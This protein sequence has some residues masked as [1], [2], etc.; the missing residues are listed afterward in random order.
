VAV[1]R[2]VHG[3][4]VPRALVPVLALFAVMRRRPGAWRWW[5]AGLAALSLMTAMGE[6]LPLRGWLYDAFLPMRYFRHSAIFR[7]FFLFAASR[8]WRSMVTRDLAAYLLAGPPAA[9]RR[10]ALVAGG[11]GLVAA[12][13][14]VPSWGRSGRTGGARG[15]ALIGRAHF[16]GV[17]LG[18]L[19]IGVAVWR[20]PGAQARRLVPVLLIL[21]AG[22]DALLTSVVSVPTVAR[23]GPQ[24]ERWRALDRQH[25]AA[26]EGRADR[27][28]SACGW[29]PGTRR[30]RRNDQLI[31]K[32]P[33]FDA[34]ASERN[35]RQQALAA[36]PVAL[37]AVTSPERLWFS[38]APAFEDPTEEA[39]QAFLARIDTLGG[40]PIVIH[41]P[42]AM[43]RPDPGQ[44][45]RARAASGSIESAPAASPTSYA[46]RRYE[47]RHLDL[48]VEAPA[49][50]WLLVTDRWARS[51][52][53]EVNG[54][55]V[56]TYAAN[57]IFRA[58][59][60]EAGP[61][62]VRFTFRPRAYPWLVL[63]SWGTL[64]GVAAGPLVRRLRGRTARAPHP[65]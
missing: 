40:M 29:T 34:Y 51:W 58:V 12:A 57:F 25:V 19:V 15:S 22:T 10:F 49:E 31:T 3:E 62:R 11:V 6:S 64:L 36:H 48:D 46:V 33:V 50:G 14:F 53:A 38:T 28:P 65:S 56:P 60:L 4:R 18:A 9:A 17:W 52:R 20:L 5:L 13:L 24:A 27:T 16:V 63:L 39:F 47:A 42:E 26:L 44:V 35:P 2:R 1:E 59:P 41:S 54:E 7:L 43:L 21:L 23:P 61:N 45:V 55:P 30:C 37:G 32:A 8:C